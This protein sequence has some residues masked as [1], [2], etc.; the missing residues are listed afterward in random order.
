MKFLKWLDTLLMSVVKPVVVILGLT[1][2]LLLAVGVFFR[3]VLDHPVFG[4]EEI[5]LLA[6]MWFYM[7]GATLASRE[8]SH[9]SADFLAAFVKNP[10][11][12]RAAA[13]LSS[14]ISLFVSIMVLTWAWDL[15]S[16]GYQRGQSTPV[17]A[18]K[19]WV[20]QA[21]LLV[22]SAF[23]VLYLLRDLAYQ[24]HGTFPTNSNDEKE[25]K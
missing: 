8:R 19:L 4:L 11:I 6:V 17:F 14:M 7:L 21:S 18:I 3:S 20:S 25:A 12:L 16:W 10:T 2:A 24:I 15:V 9:L 13:V 23:F 22:A 1:V 5:M